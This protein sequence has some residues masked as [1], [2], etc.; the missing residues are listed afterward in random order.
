MDPLERTEG[1]G[2]KYW[3]KFFSEEEG[4]EGIHRA[5]FLTRNSGMGIRTFRSAL[6]CLRTSD[7][8]DRSTICEFN[9]FSSEEK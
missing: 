3:D 9:I 7:F 2:G 6:V 1:K 4:A 5:D 8:K